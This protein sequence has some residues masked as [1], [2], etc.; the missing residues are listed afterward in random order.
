MI[1]TEDDETAEPGLTDIGV[2]FDA[3]SSKNIFLAGYEKTE[4][5][6]FQFDREGNFVRSFAHTKGR[7]RE[8]FRA[9]AISPCASPSIRIQDDNIAVSDFGNKLAVFGR[10][11]NLIK[12]SRIDSET[13]CTVP[14]SNGHFLSYRRVMEPAGA[15]INQNPLTLLDSQL[16]ETKVLERQMMPNPIV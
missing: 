13:I 1:D 14:L 2:Y 3:D 11:G 15:Y 8:N 6:I 10:E 7:A 5:M 12:E 4:G 16:E 9:A